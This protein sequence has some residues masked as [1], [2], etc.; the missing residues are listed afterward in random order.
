VAV[1][2]PGDQLSGLLAAALDGTGPAL[3]PVDPGLPPARLERLIKALA[4]DAVTAP[5][6][7]T[8]RPGGLPVR[9]GTAVVIV[10]S[11][12]T[13]APK[14]AELS[15]A[16]LLAS[17]RACLRRIGAAP[18]ER[19]LCC[20]PTSHVAG[21]QVLVRSL[22]TGTA[23][24]FCP[25]SDTAA[26]A[27]AAAAGC[28]HLAL[29]P[30]QLRRL[31]DGAAAPWDPSQLHTILLGGAAAPPGLLAEARSAGAPVVTTYGLT[32]TC[33]GCV[34]DGMPLDGVEV[35]TSKDGRIQIA[36]PVLMSGYRLEP[37][38]TAAA[39]DGRWFITS[40]LGRIA[41]D[42][43][44]RVRGRADDVISTG[45]EKVV[46]GELAALIEAY[47]PVGEA[48]VFAVP[49]PRWGERVAVAVVPAD[50]AAP[51]G[52]SGLRAHVAG[53]LPVYAAPRDLVIVPE[54]PLLP[55]GKPDIPALRALVREQSGADSVSN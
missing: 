32:E 43:H 17:A 4:P 53:R 27:S 49:D 51:P 26:I 12:S 5:D 11:G 7:I 13:G 23:P 28:A 42:G 18:G 41:A 6:G 29:V 19:W 46:A 52:L 35:R 33:G 9:D 39:F 10:T 54:I 31:L 47:E 2:P 21:I 20:L 8:R 38:V 1:L 45:G 37:D 14:A 50:Q 22:L 24:M 40:D 15:A 16:A 55:A 48:V 25:P 44:L 30:T 34:Y 3:A 36:G